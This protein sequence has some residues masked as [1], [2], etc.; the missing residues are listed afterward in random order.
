MMNGRRYEN[1]AAI[2]GG[3]I[4][5]AMAIKPFRMMD[6]SCSCLSRGTVSASY[7]QSADRLCVGN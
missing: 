6:D 1:M 7:T 4:P 2:A 3:T 5:E